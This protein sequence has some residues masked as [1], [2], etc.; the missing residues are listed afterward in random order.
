MLINELKPKEF[1][2][3]PSTLNIE[4]F[5]INSLLKITIMRI[6]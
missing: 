1:S 5:E 6:Y 4:N 3:L 2:L